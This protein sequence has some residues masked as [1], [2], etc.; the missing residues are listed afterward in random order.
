MKPKFDVGDT[1]FFM[2]IGEIEK[3][4][5]KNKKVIKQFEKFVQ[6]HTREN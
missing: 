4:I 3:I 5:Q 2:G 1:I 6:T